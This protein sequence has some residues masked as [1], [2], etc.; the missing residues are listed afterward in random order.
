MG[1]PHGF[2]KNPIVVGSDSRRTASWLRK[3]MSL[4]PHVHSR[5]P[6]GGGDWD[7]RHLSHVSSCLL[8]CDACRSPLPGPYATLGFPSKFSTSFLT[9]YY[10]GTYVIPQESANPN[11]HAR[12]DPQTVG[13]RPLRTT[14]SKRTI[15]NPAT[16]SSLINPTTASSPYPM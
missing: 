11:R 16:C 8:A 7:G 3:V 5:E 9:S 15:T 12:A 10:F 4:P 13:R 2:P 1:R 6:T 14:G